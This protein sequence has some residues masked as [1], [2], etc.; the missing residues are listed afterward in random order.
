MRGVPREPPLSVCEKRDR[1]NYKYLALKVL[2]FLYLDALSLGHGN[3][4]SVHIHVDPLLLIIFGKQDE[5][6]IK[7]GSFSTR[8]CM[9]HIQKKCL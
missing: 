9:C 5:S 7:V 2:L 3:F 4:I 8:S 1:A 6:R